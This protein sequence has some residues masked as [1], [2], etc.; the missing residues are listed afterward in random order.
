ME[1]CG[2]D[3]L[4]TGMMC[5]TERSI[6][7]CLDAWAAKGRIAV[8]DVDGA[9]DG[10]HLRNEYVLKLHKF[11]EEGIR[12]GALPRDA[13]SWVSPATVEAAAHVVSM[14]PTRSHRPEG[15]M[16]SALR[17]GQHRMRVPSS[18]LAE[19]TRGGTAVLT[20]VTN[21]AASPSSAATVPVAKAARPSAKETTPDKGRDSLAR[22]LAR[23]PDKKRELEQTLPGIDILR[24]RAAVKKFLAGKHDAAWAAARVHE[25]IAA[26]DRANRKAARDAAQASAAAR[27]D[28]E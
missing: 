21:D 9:E 19:G 17:R 15:S 7:S 27:A 1:E 23:A 14:V 8:S 2:F 5:F 26:Q 20:D 24:A 4:P 6:S 11:V 16:L 18:A 13:R 10:M 12:S 3:T 25:V 28:G 22:M